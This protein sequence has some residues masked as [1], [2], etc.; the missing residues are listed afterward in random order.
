MPTEYHIVHKESLKKVAD[1]TKMAE[2]EQ[3]QKAR[4]ILRRIQEKLAGESIIF[5]DNPSRLDHFP[6]EG[7]DVVIGCAFDNQCLLDY[8]E[9]LRKNNIPFRRD[10]TLILK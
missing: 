6:V 7:T 8:E 5:I 4:F 2:E 3:R 10:E 1:G 9:T